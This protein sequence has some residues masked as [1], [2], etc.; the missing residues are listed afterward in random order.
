[1]IKMALAAASLAALFLG[2]QAKA[3]LLWPLPVHEGCTSSFGEFRLTHFHVGVD[4]RTHQEEGWPVLA[5]GDGK[6]TRLR[7]EPEGYGR[8]LYLDLDD[9]RTAVYG[10]L[11]RYSREL[12]LEGKL[13]EACVAK[14]SSFPGDLFLSPPV[15]VK[16]GDVLA[17]SGQLGIGAPHLHFEVRRGD[18]ACDPFEE[19]LELPK[20]MEAPQIIGLAL[21]PRD[22]SGEVD[23]S[24]RPAYIPAV[25]SGP[26][27]YRLA[28]AASLCGAVDVM[29]VAKDHLGI[30]DNSTGVSQIEASLDGTRF[31]TMD[32]CCISFAKY[33][34]STLLF[35][36]DWTPGDVPAYR[37]RRAEGLEISGVTGDG[38][39][40][41]VAFGSHTL[42]VVASNRGGMHSVLEGEARF[43]EHRVHKSLALP[44]SGYALKQVRI[45][46]AGVWLS[47]SRK[48]G[49]GVTPLVLDS[50]P[51]EGL[52]CEI[53]GNE[54]EA[55]IPMEGIRGRAG[56]L[57]IGSVELSGRLAS[58]PS[59]MK[60]GAWELELP[61]GAA[62]FIQPD[63]KN[64][65]S[66]KVLCGPFSQRGRAL[67][68]FKADLA[69]G[70]HGG[71]FY[72][73]KWAKKLDGQPF[74]L[75]G[76]GLYAVGEDHTAPKWGG[77]QIATL[78][79]LGE[80]E[81]RLTV[82]DSGSG[83]DPYSLHVTLDGR[84]VYPD[85]H[86]AARQVRVDLTGVAPGRHVLAGRCSDRAGNGALLAPLSFT[87]P[88]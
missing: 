49:A 32:L 53:R 39:P 42:E 70:A 63:G 23:G 77:L 74:P 67:L 3:P 54:V 16:R 62:G 60:L 9:G 59:V 30:P 12:G 64:G 71:V 29:V 40:A 10:H 55:L 45:L 33:K 26:G 2:A 15:R 36:P 34:E 56:I 80:R 78:P 7:R 1:M 46:P 82:E 25:S 24:F 65:Q 19:G 27:R 20:G 83:P 87:L 41:G 4:M 48:D 73:G 43:A 50:R 68:A 14:G 38:L 8:V 88:R 28:R 66:V 47:L 85:W 18:E 84:P 22:A 76:D 72:N 13:Q 57:K 5:A 17:Y 86:A 44:G 52:L 75:R 69:P 11:C 58:G 21:V 51:V 79:H 6:V 37:L 81:A 31:F 35:D 61:D